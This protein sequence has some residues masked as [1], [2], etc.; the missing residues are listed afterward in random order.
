M[1][2]LSKKIVMVP[3]VYRPSETCSENL[4]VAYGRKLQMYY[5]VRQCSG[6]DSVNQNYQMAI[7]K[8]PAS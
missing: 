2:Y 8:Y 7:Q 4:V 5:P 3:V 1:A 6:H